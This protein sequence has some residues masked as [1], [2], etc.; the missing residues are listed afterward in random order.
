MNMLQLKEYKNG[1]LGYLLLLDHYQ[2]EL[3][4]QHGFMELLHTVFQYIL[5]KQTV[6]TRQLH[7]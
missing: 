1:G 4:I 7:V 3:W 5:Y 6:Q 2:I